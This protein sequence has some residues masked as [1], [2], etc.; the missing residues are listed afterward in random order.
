MATLEAG[1]RVLFRCETTAIK[2]ILFSRLATTKCGNKCVKACIKVGTSILVSLFDPN[3]SHLHKILLNKNVF[4]LDYCWS[5]D[6]R[7]AWLKEIRNFS[8]D[9]SRKVS[10][11]QC[12]ST[13][14]LLVTTR[15]FNVLSSSVLWHMLEIVFW[16]SLLTAILNPSVTPQ[17]FYTDLIIPTNSTILTILTFWT[18]HLYTINLPTSSNR[19]RHRDIKGQPIVT[20]TSLL[21]NGPVNR[22]N[23]TTNPTTLATSLHPR[24]LTPTLI[25]LLY[26]SKIYNLTYP[27]RH[28]WK[29][30]NNYHRPDKHNNPVN[31]YLPLTSRHLIQ[32][33]RLR[34]LQSGNVERNPG[35]KD[36]ERGRLRTITYNVRGLGDERKLRHL[37]N[38]MSLRKGG[39]NND[40]VACLQETYI[41]KAGKIPYIWRGNFFLTPGTGHGSGCLTLLSPHLNI[42]ESRNSNQRGHTLA[43]QRTGESGVKYIVANIYAPNPNS[44]EKIDFFEDIFNT[45][46]EFQEKY[47]CPNLIILGDFNLVLNESEIKNRSFSAQE[48]R[49]SKIVKDILATSDLSDVWESNHGFTWR[50]PGTD[51]FST[52]DRIVYTNKSLKLVEVKSNWSMSF[53]DHAAVEASFDE[54]LVKK[55]VRTRI[56]RLD[57]YLAKT[58]WARQKI[59]SDFNEM[60][61]TACP[62]WGPHMKLEFAKLCI[63]TVVENVQAERNRREASEE[64]AIN[65]ELE[66][67]IEA[68]SNH[69]GDNR[70]LGDLLEH[71]ES[72]R[73]RKSELINEKGERLAHKLGTKWY[74]EG[75]KSTRYFLRLLNRSLPDDFQSLI[76]VAGDITDPEAIEAEI[77]NFYKTLYENYENGEIQVMTNDDDFFKELE[78][79][80]M[81]K[82]D[83]VVKPVELH[84][85]T[86][87]L[88]TCNDSA[89]GP[90]GIPY[91]I[92]RVV[93]STFGPILCDAWKHSLVTGTLPD[94]HKLSYLKLIPKCGK[95][96]RHLTN[97]RPITL[98]NCDHKLITKTY[99]N[100]M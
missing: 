48:R 52:I 22:T 77:V 13:Y 68:I 58:D 95:D 70:R 63:R 45:A 88:L 97:W 54:L 24:S 90:D 87:T 8:R 96:L 73:A 99:A 94:S 6:A 35:P 74:N 27:S 79:I 4:R 59:E 57:P 76:G 32:I 19:K 61:L 66:T 51:I 67:A 17:T 46:F 16:R 33:T 40:F 20:A 31:F 34:L 37:L 55:G 93:W 15:H 10:R 89:P 7:A 50:R 82:E 9:I 12:L 84:E 92:L 30:N 78:P 91:S 62:D 64:E 65:E 23:P 1:G 29:L 2:N 60:Y 56:T 71:T 53:S 36:Q 75:E 83:N 3:T 42:V 11:P 38:Q 100:R 28:D 81:E 69:V 39:K 85:L 72:L 86:A 47:D 80:A 14:L 25:R 18:N 44:R 43:C 21:V 41:E 49:V 26:Q 98:S 5:A